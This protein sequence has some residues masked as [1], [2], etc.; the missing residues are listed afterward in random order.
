MNTTPIVELDAFVIDLRGSVD[1][2]HPSFNHLSWSGLSSLHVVRD[3]VDGTPALQVLRGLTSDRATHVD[4]VEKRALL[5]E[6]GLLICGGKSISPEAYLRR[7]ERTNAVPLEL[8]VAQCAA[9]PT[10]T[11]SCTATGFGQSGESLDEYERALQSQFL[12]DQRGARLTWT[13][14]VADSATLLAT[15]ELVSLQAE[16]TR[17]VWS[18]QQLADHG[19]GTGRHHSTQLE[20][21]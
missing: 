3:L 20:L 10:L 5:A 2:W 16:D 21:C 4:S 19:A 1:K 15:L 6:D 14:P 17:R 13:I 8:F 11:Y 7:W 18:L 9:I 12:T